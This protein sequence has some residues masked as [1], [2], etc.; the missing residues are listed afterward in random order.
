ML[1]TPGSNAA[2]GMIQKQ[3]ITIHRDEIVTNHTS[4]AKTVI[5]A[6]GGSFVSDV[7]SMLLQQSPMNQL[8]PFK[9][10]RNYTHVLTDY[11]Y[12]ENM[13]VTSSKVKLDLTQQ[14]IK[15]TGI[16]ISTIKELQYELSYYYN[17]F[18]VDVSNTT[19]DSGVDQQATASGSSIVVGTGAILAEGQS[20]RPTRG[21]L[22]AVEVQLRK[23]G[24][25]VDNVTMNIYEAVNDFP[26][27]PSLASRS[28]FGSS[29]ST[30]FSVTK[31]NVSCYLNASK[32]YCLVVTR[33]GSSNVSHY[34]EMVLGTS[35]SYAN[36]VWIQY[37][38]S[39]WG[40]YSNQDIWFKTY[41]GNINSSMIFAYRH[42]PD[43][44]IWSPWQ[45]I[46]H[47]YS[48]VIRHYLNW[49]IQQN[50]SRY[51]QFTIN[52]TSNDAHCMP[53]CYSV[54]LSYTSYE[55]NFTLDEIDRPFFHI[56]SIHSGTVNTINLTFRFIVAPIPEK[57][58]VSL[59]NI[60]TYSWELLSNGLSNSTWI[61]TGS[62]LEKYFN[63]TIYIRVRFFNT[64][65]PINLTK[66]EYVKFHYTT[67]HYTRLDKIDFNI[68]YPETI[69]M[70][71]S[72]IFSDKIN[73]S[74]I[75]LYNVIMHQYD[76]IGTN[77]TL[78]NY[79]IPSSTYY[80]GSIS[81]KVIVESI[82]PLSIQERLA[83]RMTYYSNIIAYSEIDDFDFTPELIF[84]KN[85]T[86]DLTITPDSPLLSDIYLYSPID[87]TYYKIS[88]TNPLVKLNI[89]QFPLFYNKTLISQLQI[90]S[91]V[92]PTLI[93]SLTFS[94][95]ITFTIYFITPPPT[96]VTW[97]GLTA[98]EYTQSNYLW[99]NVTSLASI[100]TVTMQWSLHNW[101]GPNETPKVMQWQYGKSWRTATPISAQ[102]YGTTVVWAIRVED[103][104]GNI[105]YAY[106]NYTIQD[107]VPPQISS[108]IFLS[109]VPI[110]Q[111]AIINITMSE[112]VG[113]SGI[114]A[115]GAILYYEV[116]SS[117]STNSVPISHIIGTLW[118][119]NIPGQVAND[120]VEFYIQIK[121]L[122]ENTYTS[123]PYI[124]SI[125]IEVPKDL[126][127]LWISLGI[128]VP[129]TVVVGYF[130]YRRVRVVPTELII[131]KRKKA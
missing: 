69:T 58:N 53:T 7:D 32:Q 122:A 88:S 123:P 15:G 19:L 37:G 11:S 112:P 108:V 8:I 86:L 48:G 75:Y 66:K 106:D 6:V 128:I 3:T 39:G 85:M 68:D 111:A 82:K 5:G 52:F 35:N 87:L 91:K 59:Y 20:F 47:Q 76:L 24:V 116:I 49:Y 96:I 100:S 25:P 105:A 102:P 31:F 30:S 36:G 10:Y 121:D 79:P 12:K 99:S 55:G 72:F 28:M 2:G 38:G 103:N 67:Y 26:S 18:Q 46:K 13:S 129:A 81:V 114:N 90:Y 107:S 93:P 71:S 73:H 124:Y 54:K 89:T 43:Q 61:L 74:S 1:L 34:Y 118:Q 113:A 83:L 44:F 98:P 94:K 57:A 60:K 77:L 41:G 131:M 21:S 9:T 109:I 125:A 16:Y 95:D 45:T 127:W 65:Y 17:F 50:L 130:I 22:S 42:S 104:V 80:N 4:M 84:L 70:N 14:Q 62:Q 27:G 23:V 33:T 40:K 63:G 78:Q 119:A 101:I 97:A 29:L 56:D 110:S 120:T 64:N 115:S 51:L 117:H 92:S 126:T